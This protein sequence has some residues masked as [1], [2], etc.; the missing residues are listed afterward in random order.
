MGL[1]I[2]GKYD[3]QAGVTA[4]I[5]STSN[6]HN[7]TENPSRVIEDLAEFDAPS[8]NVQGN[9]GIKKVFQKN[10]LPNYM[11]SNQAVWHPDVAGSI[12]VSKR[13]ETG[14]TKFHGSIHGSI[15]QH[16]LQIISSSGDSTGCSSFDEVPFECHQLISSRGGLGLI[17]SRIDG[18]VSLFK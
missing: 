3:D 18:V 1:L 12:V 17:N 16:Q 5:Y 4:K 15:L 10:T 8:I 2:C 7:L 6:I 13:I 14:T 11:C 9:Y